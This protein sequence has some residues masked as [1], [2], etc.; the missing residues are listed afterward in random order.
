MKSDISAEG[1]SVEAVLTTTSSEPMD[2]LWAELLG[3]ITDHGLLC[4]EKTIHN[5]NEPPKIQVS[6][7]QQWR[8]LY[9][10]ERNWRLPSTSVKEA[11]SLLSSA[12]WDDG[13]ASQR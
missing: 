7:T 11:T 9:K 1:G 13:L 6:L 2:L 12:P 5:W 10:P 4:A 3:T 8:I